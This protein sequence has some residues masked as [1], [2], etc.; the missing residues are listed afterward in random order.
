MRW[1]III[2]PFFISLILL[3]V[4]PPGA[5]FSGYLTSKHLGFNQS[6]KDSYE[7]QKS[8][9]TSFHLSFH[10]IP[11]NF[12]AKMPDI[13]PTEGKI[14]SLFG[15]RHHPIKKKYK[16]HSGV[17]IA[18]LKN[19]D[20]VATADGVVK[21]SSP[22]KGYGNLIVIDHENGFETYYG[23]AETLLVESGSPIKKGQVIAKMG[24]TGLATG[25]HLHYEIRFAGEALNPISFVK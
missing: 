17:D 18:N 15:M 9:K 22:H 4:F 6:F 7:G 10:P 11:H 2:V 23:H 20:I 16:M 21:I 19:T 8:K 1:F 3:A 5:V 25:D 13:W 12:D 14:S 24:Q